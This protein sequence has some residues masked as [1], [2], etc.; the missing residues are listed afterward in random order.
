VRFLQ[1]IQE[2]GLVKGRRHHVHLSA[3]RSQYV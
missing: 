1:S 2:Q 3:G